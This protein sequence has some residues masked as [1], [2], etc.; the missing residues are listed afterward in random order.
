MTDPEI[1]I[2]REKPESMPMDLYVKIQGKPG[3]EK[4]VCGGCTQPRT[5]DKVFEYY[6]KREAVDFDER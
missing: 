1:D 2:I 5:V 6:R 3:S 4:I